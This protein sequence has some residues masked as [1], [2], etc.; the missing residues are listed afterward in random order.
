MLK[1]MGVALF[2]AVFFANICGCA[3]LLAGAAG[4]AG[5]AAWLGGKLS[6]QV[7]VPKDKAVVAVRRAMAALKLATVKETATDEVFQ[8]IGEY[9]DGRQVWIDVRALS[10]SSSKIEVRVGATGDK[11]A[12][13]S[14]MN[15][16]KKYL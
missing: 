8:L 16:I 13:E 7:E 6:Q 10:S 2:S 4:G 11:A 5:T 1:R 14:I 3:L 9:T 15:K 12:A